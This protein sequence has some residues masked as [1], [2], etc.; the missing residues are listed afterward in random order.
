MSLG[1]SKETQGRGGSIKSFDELQ[2][3][4]E[5]GRRTSHLGNKLN[6]RPSLYMQY[7]SEEKRSVCLDPIESAKKMSTKLTRYGE[8]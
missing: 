4:F 5:R 7:M 8:I 3:A 2:G 6:E 1:N